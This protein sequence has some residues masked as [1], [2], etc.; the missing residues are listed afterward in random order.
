VVV[1]DGLAVTLAPLV[2]E[3]PVAG[4]Q[5]KLVAP[6]AESATLAPLQIVGEAGVTDTTGAGSTVTV[7]VLVDVQPLAVPVTV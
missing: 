5:E 6:L 4:D 7:T 1:L 2:A 3:R